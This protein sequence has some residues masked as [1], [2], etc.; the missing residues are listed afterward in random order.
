MKNEAV[1][2]KLKELGWDITPEVTLNMYLTKWALVE[3]SRYEGEWN[4]NRFVTH[5]QTNWKRG[6]VETT[7]N[8]GQLIEL[9]NSEDI[10]EMSSDS[11]PIL[12]VTE[13][14]DG[15]V[16]CMETQWETPL[17]EEDEDKLS[18]S[19]EDLF[20]LAD[21]EEHEP[22]FE[23]GSVWKMVIRVGNEEIDINA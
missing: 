22:D 1:I 3:S 2:Q 4:E 5:T 12:Y 15:N 11:F 19:E 17:T 8:G 21:S 6:T 10:T 7:M 14:E 20:S 13:G 9:L 16:D 23:V 18:D